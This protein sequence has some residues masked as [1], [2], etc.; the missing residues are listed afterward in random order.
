MCPNPLSIFGGGGSKGGTAAS[1]SS[2]RSSQSSTVNVT[3]NVDTRDVANAIAALAQ[4]QQ[5]ASSL[6]LLGSL[7]GAGAT[8]QAARITANSGPSVYVIGGA[9]VAILGLLFTAGAI[10]LPRS[11]RAR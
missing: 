11:L 3:T 8:V 9:I 2:S 10:K 5:Q 1:T 4:E 7:A 6:A